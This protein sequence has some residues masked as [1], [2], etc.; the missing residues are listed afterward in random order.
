MEPSKNPFCFTNLN[1]KRTEKK[2]ALQ[3]APNNSSASHE[4]GLK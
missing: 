2:I 3:K 1:Q 4:A